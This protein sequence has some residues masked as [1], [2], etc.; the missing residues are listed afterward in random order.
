MKI[1]TNISNVVEKN[2][3][4]SKYDAEVKQV[5]SDPQILAWILKYTTEEL[6]DCSIAHIISCMEGKPEVGKRY[7]YD[8]VTRGVFYCARMLSSQMGN[9]ISAK[10][11]DKLKKVYSIWICLDVP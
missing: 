1:N 6:K 8:I 7:V 11:Y 9:E 2:A 4:M 5:L 3:D 10:E